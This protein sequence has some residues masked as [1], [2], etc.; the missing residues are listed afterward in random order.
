MSTLVEPGGPA[1]SDLALV[2]ART[3]S[4]ADLAALRDAVRRSPASTPASTSWTRSRPP[5][6]AATTPRRPRSCNA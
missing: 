5:S 1:L 3:R 2:W 4:A 6:A